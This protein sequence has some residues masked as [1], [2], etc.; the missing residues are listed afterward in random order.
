M[1]GGG[2]KK[3]GAREHVH[4]ETVHLGFPLCIYYKV[5]TFFQTSFGS[6]QATQR[7]KKWVMERGGNG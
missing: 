4:V 5:V 1:T 2:G 3:K 6:A 7:W